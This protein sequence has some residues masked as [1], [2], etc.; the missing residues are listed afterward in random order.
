MAGLTNHFGLNRRMFLNGCAGSLGPLALAHLLKSERVLAGADPSV[1]GHPLAASSSDHPPRARAV[2]SLFQNGGPSQ[3]DLFD[4]K[5]ALNRFHGQPYPGDLE[6]HFH[7]QVG[8]VLA[9]PFRFSKS[10]QCGMELSELLP[11]TAKIADRITLVRSMHTLSVDHE[12]ALHAIH[13]GRVLAGHPV[14]GSWLVYAL[15]TERLELPAYVVLADPGGQ[16]VDGIRNWSSGYLPAICQGTAFG[17]GESAVLNLKRPPDVSVAARRNQLELLGSFNAAHL[18]VH[19]DNSELAAH[20]ANYELASQMQTSV[21]EVLDI[22]GETEQTRQMY[23]LDNPKISEYGQRC[24]LAR[25]LVEQGVRFVQIFMKSQP[26]DTH[27]RNAESLRDLT[28][29]TDQPCAALVA[30]LAQ[31]GLLDSTIVMF[32]GEFGRLPVSQ[33]PDGRDHNRRAFSLWLA[34]GGF[35]GGCDYGRTDD[36]GYEVA[37]DAVSVHDL[38][39]TLLHLLGIDHR[40]LTFPHAGRQERLTDADVTNAHVVKQLIS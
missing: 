18:A 17:S 36:F 20:I 10:G 32:A 40:Q 35:R 13:T 6:T 4:P 26:W 38:H 23:G 37:E 33:G 22:S 21:P 9:S 3:M 12:Q 16:P 24:L 27:S 5:P 2:I 1:K 7:T 30:D 19:Q 11:H 31:R 29:R 39:A 28:A 14:W 25:R 34:G 8:N 15:G